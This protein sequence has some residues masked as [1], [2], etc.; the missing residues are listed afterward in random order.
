MHANFFIASAKHIIQVC[1]TDG[2]T[3]ENVCILRS[4]S[5]GVRV[6]Y[7]GSCVDNDGETVSSICEA[8]RNRG[9]CTA[10]NST[11]Q[12]LVAPVTGCCP[13]CGERFNYCFYSI[14]TQSSSVLEL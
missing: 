9:L 7:R 8:V 14:M 6:D 5:S 2:I 4:Q 13:I 11:C 12:T 3:Y 1:G 10:S